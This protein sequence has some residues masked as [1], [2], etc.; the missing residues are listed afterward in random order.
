MLDAGSGEGYGTAILASAGAASA[1][2]I[3]LDEESITHAR[4]R[5]GQ[6]FEAADIASLPFDNASFDLVVCFETIEH[7]DDDVGALRELRRV[8]ADDGLL[9]ISTPNR[10][11]YL[12][13]NEFHKREYAPAEFDALLAEH[14]AE[15]HWLY[16]QNWLLSAVLDAETFSAA[17]DHKDG[18]A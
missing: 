17:D 7:L 6:M 16:Q 11:E 8:L 3:D 14:F 13:E 2:G 10:D 15:R 4:E 9:I 12:V 5:Y 1:V 18:P